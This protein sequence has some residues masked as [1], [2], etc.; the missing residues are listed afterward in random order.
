MTKR[1][2]LV[3]GEVSG[4]LHAAALVRA[5]RSR[6]EDVFFGGI[7]G[8]EL[9]RAGMRIDYHVRD[10]AVL[11]LAEVL[12]RYGFFRRVFRDMVNRLDRERPD[13]VLL[14]D[15]PGFN[16][17]LAKEAHRRGIKVLYYICPQVWAWHRSRISLMADIIDR[18]MV[19]FPF[20]PAVFAGTRLKVDF[21]GHPLVDV[22]REVLRE[23]P[24]EVPWP[25]Q[26]HVA[27]LPGSRVQEVKRILPPMLGAARLLQQKFPE[28]GFLIA[29]PNEE[30][31]RWADSILVRCNDGGLK[32]RVV[33]GM[34]RHV[35]RQARAAMVAS[36]T[37][38]VETALLGCPMMIVYR[39]AAPTYWIGRLLVRVDYLG[40]VNL[41]LGRG[42]F[43][44]FIQ[45]NARPPAM[46][47]TAAALVADTACRQRMLADLAEVGARLGEG[48]ASER[49][50]QIVMEEL[51]LLPNAG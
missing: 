36:G 18:L 23:P 48:G 11:G 17:R 2:L 28:A 20:E 12:R 40:M 42:A 21:V 35:L 45:Y 5:V 46:A 50:A 39:A 19:I 1:V 32:C 13:A 49:A 26:P 6:T 30:I 41:I 43:P 3:A 25:G 37:A 15:Y 4:D 34:T 22:I 24:P 8:D 7:G 47:D 31:G 16:L 38:T 51:G 33:S 14:V 9:E 29:A 27:L 44:E 10:M